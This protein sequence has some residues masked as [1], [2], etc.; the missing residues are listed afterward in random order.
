MYISF[1]FAACCLDIVNK[2]IREKSGAIFQS[3]AW[4]TYVGA[5]LVP[6]VRVRMKL[7]CIQ[8]TVH[9]YKSLAVVI[10]MFLLLL[11]KHWRVAYY[12]KYCCIRNF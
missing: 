3:I 4:K 5:V 7:T 10:A 2:Q 8:R 12:C 9:T 1:Q 6:E 11:L